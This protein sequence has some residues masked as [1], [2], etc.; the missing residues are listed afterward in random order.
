MDA[1]A[2]VMSDR[3]SSLTPAQKYQVLQHFLQFMDQNYPAAD[4]PEEIIRVTV[5][6]LL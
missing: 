3:M 5:E 4:Q 1:I 6:D 2:Q